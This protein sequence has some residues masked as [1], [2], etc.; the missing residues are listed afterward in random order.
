[1]AWIS[2]SITIVG[3]TFFGF[4][5]LYPNM[6]LSSMSPEYH[7]S[8]HNASS[9]PHTLKIMLVITIIFVPIVIAYQIWAY[10]LFK[11][12]VTEKDLEYDNAY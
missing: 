6:F 11:G 7:L 9:S 4:V 3:A 8:V 1:M 5:G 10:S 12:K 2:S